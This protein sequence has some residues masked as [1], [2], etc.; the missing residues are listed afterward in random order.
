MKLDQAKLT[1]TAIIATSSPDCDTV[2]GETG[3]VAVTVTRRKVGWAVAL[4]ISINGRVWHEEVN[5]D[6]E[7]K[8]EFNHLWEE[9]KRNEDRLH[10]EAKGAAAAHAQMFFMPKSK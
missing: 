6:A 7:L 2:I 5:P 10:E 4:V 9:G 1:L 3:D 8:A